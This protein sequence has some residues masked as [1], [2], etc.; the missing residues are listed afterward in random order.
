MTDNEK[1]FVAAAERVKLLSTKPSNEDLLKLYSFYKQATIG[2]NKTESPGYFDFT[3][4]A[5]WKAWKSVEGMT[6]PDAQK[7]YVELVQQMETH[8]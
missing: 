1:E 8:H 7:N 3:G 5:K 6:K 2:D 4:K